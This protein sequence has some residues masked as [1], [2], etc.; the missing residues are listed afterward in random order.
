MFVY[1]YY[2]MSTNSYI[3]SNCES[4]YAAAYFMCYARGPK[5]IEGVGVRLGRVDPRRILFKIP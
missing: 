3:H 2:V 5:F 1:L 4:L